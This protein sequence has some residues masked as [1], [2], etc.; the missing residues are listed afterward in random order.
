[1]PKEV[2]LYNRLG[3][4]AMLLAGRRS[5]YGPGS[6]CLNIVDHRTNAHRKP[7][8]QDVMDGV[9]VADALP[10]IDFVM[11]M[12][13]PT[14]VN[15]E[16][17]DRYQ[18]EVMLHRT[19]KPLVFVTY[20]FEGCRDA[21]EMA[22]AVAGGPA[23]LAKRPFVTCYIN[24]TSGLL[25]NQEALQKLLFLAGKGLPALYIPVGMGGINGPI[26]VAGVYAMVNAGAL[27]GIVISQ[28]KREGAPVIMPGM[29]AG[30]IDMRTLTQ[31]Y[32][33]PDAR[34]IGEALA[35]YYHLPMFSLAGATDSKAVDQQAAVE[36]ALTLLY[37]AVGGG[38]LVHDLGYLESGLT[39]SLAQ[40]T[41]CNEIVDWVKSSLTPI[42]VND[43]T[44]ALDL[45]DLIGPDGQLLDSDHTLRHFRERWYPD[46]IERRIYG[47]WQADGAKTLA[48]R[49]AER[50]D[51]ILASHTAAPLSAEAAEAIRAVVLRAEQQ[52]GK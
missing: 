25:H 4:P 40:L 6:D 52:F 33:M 14:D 42:E 29:G 10:H 36:A 22:E 30:V 19:T 41:I 20:E 27:A 17:A 15:Q 47:E 46:L 34:G 23:A 9:T 5:Y 45:I 28:L 32:V 18:M 1:V 24:V 48:Q 12:F 39:T 2:T 26:T 43:E 16:I 50:V 3:E 37:T 7:V 8:L 11:S 38:H 31:P 35:H 21:I 51:E 13:L 44:L 49:A